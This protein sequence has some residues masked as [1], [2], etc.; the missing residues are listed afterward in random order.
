MLFLGIMNCTGGRPSSA[1]APRWCSGWKGL[2][3]VCGCGT[4]GHG[5]EVPVAVL[6]NGGTSPAQQFPEQAGRD[7]LESLLAESWCCQ[8]L[9]KS[10]QHSHRH[11][12]EPFPSEFPHSHCGLSSQNPRVHAQLCLSPAGAEG[13]GFPQGFG[14][15]A[16]QG[17]EQFLAPQQLWVL[18]PSLLPPGNGSLPW[19]STLPFNSALMRQ[20]HEH[21][22]TALF[23]KD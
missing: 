3:K 13:S 16:W 4:W 1:S 14:P 20:W 10:L 2:G 22:T 18:I 19:T 12:H 15:E 23:T 8:S 9:G 7:L 5:L 21:Q 11:G 17:W 6:G